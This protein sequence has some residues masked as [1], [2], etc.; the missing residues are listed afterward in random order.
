MITHDAMHP[1][2][3]ALLIGL[4]QQVQRYSKEMRGKM[5]NTSLMTRRRRRMDY[6]KY[7]QYII[8][9]TQYKFNIYNGT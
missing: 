6:K 8:M 3:T 7:I 2:C 5:E 4:P 9:V 1:S